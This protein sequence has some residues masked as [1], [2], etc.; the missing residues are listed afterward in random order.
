[1]QQRLTAILGTLVAVLMGLGIGG[2]VAIRSEPT[3]SDLVVPT[4]ADAPSP[5]VRVVPGP[6]Q[7]LV[8][9]T[10]TKATLRGTA[11]PLRLPL[12]V[13]TAAR[14]A[15]G[16]RIEGVTV[17]GSAST[18]VWNAGQPLDLRGA[19]A[20]VPGSLTIDV[21]AGGVTWHLD[22][23]ARHLEPARYETSA[24][25]AVGHEGL[26]QPH[27]GIA[28]E[29]TP[30]AT[31]ATQGGATVT[32]PRADLHVEGPGPVAL[33][34]DLVLRT[35]EG[36]RHVAALTTSAGA[37]VVSLGVTGAPAGAYTVDGL[38]QSTVTTR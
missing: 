38:L 14:G 15:G 37:F 25:V 31:I 10:V 17:G 13:T 9:G 23:A 29:A 1:M 4:P 22:G 11:A 24:S 33:E 28:F 30:A 36:E 8:S 18:V 7:T 3:A 19:G 34:G 5:T 35:A 32:T 16:A 6:G 21:A 26:A 27:D 2:I 20:I 12:T